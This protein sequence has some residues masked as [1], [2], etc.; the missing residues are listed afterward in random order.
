MVLGGM[1]LTWVLVLE[2]GEVVD[3]FVDDDVEVIGLI[4]RRHVCLREGLGH[5]CCCSI[6]FIYVRYYTEEA[7]GIN[8]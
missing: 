3:I 8:L 6:D 4:M 5:L 2:F 7:Q 1:Y